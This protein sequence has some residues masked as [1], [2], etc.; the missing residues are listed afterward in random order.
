MLE[1]QYCYIHRNETPTEA[2][3]HTLKKNSSF[4]TG[5]KVW[6][7]I[8]KNKIVNHIANNITEINIDKV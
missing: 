2:F 4:Q 1:S 6:K 3:K 7:K 8:K 5:F